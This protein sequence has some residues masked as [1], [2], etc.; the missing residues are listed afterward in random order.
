MN[1]YKEIADRIKAADAVLIG[2]SNGL[3]IAEGYNIFVNDER[4][5]EY[6]A[7]FQRKYGFRSLLQGI[8]SNFT[9]E[10]ER[11]SYFSR[12]AYH[13]SFHTK[14]SELMQA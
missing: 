7:D 1:Q 13:Y 10:G 14:P 6:F 2:A 3:S 11:W 4:F 8:F 5:S 9:S 12:M